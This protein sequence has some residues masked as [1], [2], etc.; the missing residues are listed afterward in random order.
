MFLHSLHFVRRLPRPGPSCAALAG[1]ICLLAG[2]TGWAQT[3]VYTDQYGNPTVTVDMSVL[4]KLGPEQRLPDLYRQTAPVPS[5]PTPP[6]L[7]GSGSR[8][9]LLAPPPRSMPKSHL[10]LPE[11]SLPAPT[12]G[13]ERSSPRRLLPPSAA[14]DR[15]APA[16]PVE[17][18]PPARLSAAPPP[19]APAAPPASAAPPLAPPVAAP[20]EAP[21]PV[22]PPSARPAPPAPPQSAARVSPPPP[23][24]PPSAPPVAA[25]PVAAPKVAPPA[26]PPAGLPPVSPS[27]ATVRPPAATAMRA[28]AEDRPAAAPPALRPPAPPATAAPKQTETAAVA[29][30][31]A[32]GRPGAAFGSV[33]VSPDGNRYEIPFA[34]ESTDLPDNAAPALDDLAARMQKNPDLRIQLMGYAGTRSGSA[35]QARRASLFRALA[36]RTHLM[37]HGIRSTRMD[38]RALGQGNE[39]GSPDRV[40][41]VVQQ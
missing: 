16:R 15:Q 41:I 40:D 22:A 6:P 19:A 32:A 34:P 17:P 2:A 27:T 37:K 7:S 23:P 3:T 38:V 20:A 21:K 12:A 9:G 18:P 5:R 1:G 24:V 35:S 13:D 30:P 8:S 36:I 11:G 14:P 4:E 33:V 10:N 31:P 25:P 26:P 28:P 39:Q 29:P